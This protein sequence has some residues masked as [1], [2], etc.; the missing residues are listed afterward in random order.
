MLR[1]LLDEHLSPAICAGLKRIDPG[2]EVHAI[3]QWK[4]GHFLGRP[5]LEILTE[6]VAQG[7]TLVTY[8]CRSIPNLL[9]VW[10]E[11]GRRHAGVVFVDEKTLNPGDIG[12]LVRALASLFSD[13]G[14]LDWE[15]REMFLPRYR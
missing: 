11:Q 12:G 6:G 4:N 7:L 2:I 9:R 10:G 15:G 13:F 3:S 14:R 1:F 8:D 5:D